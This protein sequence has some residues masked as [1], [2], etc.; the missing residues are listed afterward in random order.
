MNA[1]QLRLLGAIS[2]HDAPLA[3]PRKARALLSYIALAGRPFSR[4]ELVQIFCA[5]AIDP[6]RTLRTLLSH[7]NTHAPDLLNLSR[8][9]VS[10]NEDIEVDC[11][12]LEKAVDNERFE[13]GVIDLYRG[14]FMAGEHLPDS[15]MY[16]MWLLGR[17]AHYQSLFEKLLLAA[18]HDSFRNKE[19]GRTHAYALRLVEISPYLEAGHMMV[20]RSLVA[21]NQKQ[22]AGD[23]F[24]QFE[25]LLA[26]ELGLEPT[27]EMRRTVR[28]L[29]AGET[30]ADEDLQ[31]EDFTSP[32]NKR[33]LLFDPRRLRRR[34][35][36]NAP[37]E[38][39]E[40]VCRW[41]HETAALSTALY[42]YYSADAALETEL[43]A[44]GQL[45][46]DKEEMSELL[47]RR[48]LL[49]DYVDSPLAE[50][51]RMLGQVESWLRHSEDDDLLAKR[52]L[53]RASI[54]YRAGDYGAAISAA[55]NA[56]AELGRLGKKRLTGRA[57]AIKGQSL[58]RT[59]DNVQAIVTL[60]EA[61][62]LLSIA[63]DLEGQSLAYGE[64]AWAAINLGQ[65]ERAFSIL[66]QA[67]RQFDPS[68]R[69][70][71]TSRL[72]YT[73]AACWNYY[74][75]APEME[76]WANE[77]ITLYE[78]LGNRV[79]ANRC[80]IY[81][82]QADRYRLHN[83]TIVE[84]LNR[85]L[86]QSRRFDD[87]WTS[88]WAMVLLGLTAFKNGRLEEARL[89]YEEAYGLRRKTG[90][91][92]NQVYDLV[93]V[94]RL[95]AALRRLDSA[96]MDTTAAVRQMEQAQDAYF[97]WEAWDMHLAHAEVLQ[98]NGREKAALKRLGVAYRVLQDFLQGVQLPRHRQQI[99]QS[100]NARHL[101]E[102][103]QS[104]VIVPFH[105]R[106]HRI[107]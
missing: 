49:G 47:M 50:Q 88:A 64:T 90:E 2:Y 42:A 56:G 62:N 38:T 106:R 36:R 105:Q 33:R 30:A 43:F 19:F 77:A 34:L 39:L 84:R 81:L 79:M 101:I 28:D 17:R 66:R 5:E 63:R 70:P 6:R 24:A 32:F 89:W 3:A 48:I 102:A 13:D 41:A 29:L 22:A 4:S 14:E 100:E 69:S 37:R 7:I 99:R 55:E 1:P 53:C 85:L 103:W 44:L 68:H 18:G 87:T 9:Q 61:Q 94:G 10:L 72:A 16:E 67:L 93:Y 74:Y 86:Q 82:L 40:R 98:Q 65:I 12:A 73:M 97:S 92:Q 45:Q 20:I 27:P 104:G 91:R 51:R 11:I 57:A 83:S 60:G 58:L 75:D 96:L 107:I 15:P 35:G 31:L 46:A 78:R 59:G 52:L 71:I 76:H 21:L 23:Y 26:D 8:D 95:R 54:H 25:E 80:Q